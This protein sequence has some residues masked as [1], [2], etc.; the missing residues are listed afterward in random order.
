[1]NNFISTAAFTA[2]LAEWGP[3][4]L[5]ALLI[6]VL[7]YVIGRALKAVLAR[8][9]DRLPALSQ[10]NQG[11]PPEKTA[12]ANLGEVAYWLVLLIG[13]VAALNV[14]SLGQ[15]AGPL[16][17]LLD[18]VMAYV[19]NLIGAGLIFFIG[20]I[21]ATLARRLVTA[22]LSAVHVDSLISKLG[23]SNATPGTT[24]SAATLA[25]AVGL[26]V[27]VLILIPV[28]IAALQALN[29]QAISGPAIAVLGTILAAVP[30]V[31][32]AGII[33]AIGF[34]I[35]RWIAGV[36]QRVL[37][38]TGL[39]RALGGLSDLSSYRPTAGAAAPTSATPGS[40]PMP[41][42]SPSKVVANIV[43][44]A[45][46]AFTAIE[47]AQTLNFGAVA[48][49]LANVLTLA[50]KIVMGGAIIAVG[51]LVADMLANLLS[52]SGGERL[53][54]TVVRWAAIALAVAMG[55]KF[56]GIADEIVM[57]AFGL[58]LGS[59]AVAAALAFGL[60]GREAAGNLAEGWVRKLQ[61]GSD[62]VAA[63]PRGRVMHAKASASAR[64]EPRSVIE[65][66]SETPPPPVI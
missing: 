66:E 61:G 28:S 38:S 65:D 32:A 1:M 33:L 40:Q 64:A 60:G 24:P 13:V 12:G 23:L 63:A 21:V 42:V 10:H 57:L 51:V 15:V 25:N 53:A 5:G 31:I 14:L 43:F 11:L 7:A 56:M 18:N 39:D 4:I 26:L 49:I 3:K 9:L 47:A 22:A 20:Y 17:T 45:I 16:N 48:V 44:F 54:A 27:F 62:R 35:G 46:L 41:R 37:P 19:P 34:V 30:R 58:I 8:S 50:G 55:L 29:I 52:R 2:L 36:I 59:A 6:L